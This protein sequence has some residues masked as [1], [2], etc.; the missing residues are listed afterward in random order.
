M[1][2]PTRIGATASRSAASRPSIP[3]KA[4]SSR[5][6]GVGFDISCGVRTL[7][8]GLTRADIEPVKLALADSLF[9]HVPAGVGSTGKLELDAAEMDAMLRRRRALGGRARLRQRRG[10]AAHRGKRRGGRRL[11]GRRLR[12]GQDAGSATRWA[13]SAPAITISRCRRSSK[14]STDAAAAAS[15]GS[16]RARSWSAS[17]AARAASATRSAPSICARWRSPRRS[18]ASRCPISSSPARRSRSELGAAL[19]RRDA[20]RD[21]LRARQPADHHASD[22]PRVRPFLPA[23]AARPAV[24][25]FAQHL[26]GGDA[27]GRWQAR[28]SC[29]SIAR[30]RRA[31]SVRAIPICRL[32]CGR[33]A[34]R[35]SSAA[36]WA[37]APAIMAGT[38]RRE[39]SAPSPPP[40]TARAAR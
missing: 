27:S 3:R 40:A 25:R 4:A 38:R 7:L 39:R 32:P 18:S 19:S 5:A 10:P 9:R 14:S 22:A 33:S 23:G 1:P 35:C 16:R 26:Q 29:S 13:R 17:I 12:A 21:Q 34:S 37:R 6:G 31:P 2:C 15:S 36:A 11:A 28:A 20:R 30:A 8:T 24:R